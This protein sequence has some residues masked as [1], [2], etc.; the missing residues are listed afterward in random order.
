MAD[1]TAACWDKVP[2]RAPLFTVY[3]IALSHQEEIWRAWMPEIKTFLPKVAI[4]FLEFTSLLEGEERARIARHFNDVAQGRAAPFVHRTDFSKPTLSWHTLE[5]FIQNTGK[6]IYLEEM[7]ARAAELYE[8]HGEALHASVDLFFHRRYREAG[9]KYREAMELQ[10]QE[11]ELRDAEISNQL[12]AIIERERGDV[13]LILGGDHAP[14]FTHTKARLIRWEP[15]PYLN[16]A[17]ELVDSVR[18]L[19]EAD[20]E[21]FLFR[22]IGLFW[23]EGYWEEAGEAG[24]NAIERA[25]QILDELPLPSLTELYDFITAG[26]RGDAFFRAILWLKRAGALREEWL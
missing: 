10:L 16:L 20:L 19:P 18:T 26:K 5:E 13:L 4:I 15:R 9:E 25:I 7:P 21:E 14:A 23:V 22:R 6:K 2:E 1:Y 12:D 24:I 8:R 3:H 17:R 11:I